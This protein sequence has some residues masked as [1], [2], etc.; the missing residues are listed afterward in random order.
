MLSCYNNKR[1]VVP[2]DTVA[3]N[4]LSLGSLGPEAFSRR[5]MRP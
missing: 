4:L 5:S 2:I 3:T 1:K